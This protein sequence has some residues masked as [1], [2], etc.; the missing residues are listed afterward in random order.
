MA[1]VV[2]S[3]EDGF[4]RSSRS[5]DLLW[6]KRRLAQNLGVSTRQVEI[7]VASGR[8]PK[9]IRLGVHPMWR[10]AEVRDWLSQ[11]PSDVSAYAAT[12]SHNAERETV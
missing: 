7:L 6:K 12:A 4:Y 11:V 2:R 9:P 10:V 3:D 8:L 5:T 1:E